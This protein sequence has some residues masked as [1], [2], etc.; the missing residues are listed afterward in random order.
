MIIN[1]ATGNTSAAQFCNEL[2]LEK[3]GGREGTLRRRILQFFFLSLQESFYFDYGATRES[4]TVGSLQ[5][6]ELIRG[7][8]T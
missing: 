3:E 2:S 8:F 5:F 7:R 6:N 1:I 4:S